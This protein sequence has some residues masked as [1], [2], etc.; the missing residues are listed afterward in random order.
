MTS[1]APRG[2][3]WTGWWGSTWSSEENE[4]DE[5]CRRAGHRDAKRQVVEATHDQGDREQGDDDEAGPH[6][7]AVLG[8]GAHASGHERSQGSRR[9]VCERRLQASGQA[10]RGYQ[11]DERRPHDPAHPGQGDH[12]DHCGHESASFGPE[13]TEATRPAMV[14]A[15]IPSSGATRE[16]SRAAPPAT[17]TPTTD[18]RESMRG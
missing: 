10:V 12:G 5:K 4:V 13:V 16:T 3:L 18:D 11:Q 9:K 1:W 14:P 6:G 7:G 2:F 17:T 15:R 8:G